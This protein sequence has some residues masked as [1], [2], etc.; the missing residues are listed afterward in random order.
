MSKPVRFLLYSVAALFGI[1]VLGVVAVLLFFDVNAY[2]PKLE[3]V[4]SDLS[5]MQVTLGGKLNIGF[6]PDV[7]VVLHDVHVRNRGSDLVDA[8][9]VVVGIDVLP[10][11]HSQVRV[12]AL[13]LQ[14]VSVTIE[15]DRD[16]HFNF[17][18][19]GTKPGLLPGVQ[20]A[21]V[22]ISDAALHYVDKQSGMRLEFGGCD[23][24]L[25]TA[26]LTGGSSADFL[27]NLS[28]K[29]HVDCAKLQTGDV[30]A[31]GLA[32]PLTAEGGLIDA[33][34]VTMVVFGG[35]GSGSLHAG[36]SGDT[37]VYRLDY[38]IAGFDAQKAL[39]T[40]ASHG[41]ATGKLDFSTRLSLQGTASKP[42]GRRADGTVSLHAENLTLPGINLDDSI[43]NFKS[44]QSFNLVDAGAFLLV[45]PFGVALTKGYDFASITQATQGGTHI[46]KLVSDWRVENGLVKAQD[47]AM[48]TEKNRVAVKGAMDLV[49][50]RYNDLT[51]AVVN[52]RG[53][54]LV[55]QRIH[56]SFAHP[57]IEQPNI[58]Q[59]MVAPAVKLFGKVRDLLPHD[60][61]EVFYTGS[62]AAPGG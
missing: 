25:G 51:V 20:L 34:P 16:G 11:M 56:G 29:A 47:V 15:R 50:G 43:E 49:N 12:H 58:L 1:I 57:V 39:Q 61:C 2:K 9:R 3:A 36:L 44:S 37:P 14:H 62:V 18:N 55:E 24:D 52:A 21:G 26:R 5:G 32:F 22:S 35:Q 13:S 10:L 23:V 7:S 30:T 19:P 31:T 53:C 60:K 33:K 42:I 40:V 48:A 38:S 59:T 8:G 45:G 4:A 17:Q 6:F 28:L 46:R 27:K 41:K 54:A